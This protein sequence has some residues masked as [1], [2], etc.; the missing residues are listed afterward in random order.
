[1]PEGSLDSARALV[2]HV[3]LNDRSV[4]GLRAVGR[5]AFSVQFHPEAAP[6]PSDSLHLFA[7]FRERM[8]ARRRLTAPLKERHAEAS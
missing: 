5:D 7:A 4:E 3:S 6:G 2:T 8:L 1:V